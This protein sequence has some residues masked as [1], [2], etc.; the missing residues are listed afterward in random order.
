MGWSGSSEGRVGI[1]VQA[2]RLMT[3][4]KARKTADREEL[5]IAIT[6]LCDSAQ[7]VGA[8][9]A[10]SVQALLH[11][12]FMCLVVEA[13]RDIRR[14]LAEK[15]AGSAWAPRALINVLAL[16]DIEIARPIIASSPVLNDGDLVR[17]LVEA[18]IEHQIEVA[19]RPRI[20]AP[21]VEAILER[22]EPAVL[23]ALAAN[24]SAAVST[25]AMARLVE[26]S[27]RVTSL[28]APLARHSQLTADLAKRLYGWV[29]QALR[30]ELASRFQIDV[31]ALDAVIAE[32]VS[33]SHEPLV[34]TP[35]PLT[36][37]RAAEREEMEKRLIS[38]LND[39]GQLRPGY[40]LR[41]LRE[42][43]LTLFQ[44]ALCELGG[45]TAE[46]VRTAID[47]DKPELLALACSSVGVDRSVFPT[48]LTLVRELNGGRPAGEID[49]ARRAL[50]A[51]GAHPGAA[52]A[53]AF[54]HA[55]AVV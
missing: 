33:D 40:L 22:E 12:I 23:T 43:R 55:V 30:S 13:E 3:L 11:E 24:D 20:G 2:E 7:N 32:A 19:R 28:R 47:S 15:L 49:S 17:L 54:R 16:D 34:E 1:A 18:T 50:G 45:F 38:K 6:D 29:G 27:R 35:P 52:A 25:Q 26:T 31:Q 21:V 37:E 4:A 8:L 36:R 9:D 46:Q 48:I 41:A 5:L 39:S 14:R 51:F 42:E 53:T 44:A 10:D